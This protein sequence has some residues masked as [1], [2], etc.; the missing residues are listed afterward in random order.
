M[1]NQNQINDVY[2]RDVYDQNGE[3]IGTIGQVFTDDAGRPEFA[4]VRTGL[5]GMKESFIPLSDVSLTDEGLRVPFT[6]NQVKDA[7]NIDPDHGELTL[8]EEQQL[9]NHFGRSREYSDWQG[10]Q[11][12]SKTGGTGTRLR[13]YTVVQADVESPRQR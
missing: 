12:H 13:R 6:K 10:Q 11:T 7:P 1:L 4:S 8:D 5:L 2:D 9:Y 3:K